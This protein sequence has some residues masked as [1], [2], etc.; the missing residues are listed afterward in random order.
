MELPLAHTPPMR[1]LGK[2]DPSCEW[3][4]IH[5]K[6]HRAISRVALGFST[7]WP[8]PGNLTT[9]RG[10]PADTGAKRHRVHMTAV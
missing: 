1:K 8:Q 10:P 7:A 9:T 5:A 6:A 4:K 3:I 2:K